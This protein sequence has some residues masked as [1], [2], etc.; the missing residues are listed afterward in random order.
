M[1]SLP[2]RARSSH[3]GGGG[4]GRVDGPG[5]RVT[6]VGTAVLPSWPR[7]DR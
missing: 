1:A 3:S 6:N 2:V 5:Q 7:L 4:D